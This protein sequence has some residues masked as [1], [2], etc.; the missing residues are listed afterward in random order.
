[1]RNSL[2][3]FRRQETYEQWRDRMLRDTARY[4]EWGLA[5]PELVRRIPTHPVG[6]GAFTERAKS[7]FWTLVFRD[8]GPPEDEAT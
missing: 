1:M 8:P 7:I 3:T 2:G 4:I 6:K 5:H